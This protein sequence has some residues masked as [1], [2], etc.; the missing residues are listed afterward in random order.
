MGTHNGIRRNVILDYQLK[1]LSARNVS[2]NLNKA[3]RFEVAPPNIDLGIFASTHLDNESPS[4]SLSLLVGISNIGISSSF[5]GF[6][7]LILIVF[8]CCC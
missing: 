5:S 1:P 3:L 8:P 2:S 6:S 7:P 4:L